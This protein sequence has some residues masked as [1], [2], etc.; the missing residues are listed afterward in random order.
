M[1]GGQNAPT[2]AAVEAQG[3]RH[4]APAPVRASA[5]KQKVRAAARRYKAGLRKETAMAAEAERL[6]ASK[7]WL[8]KG[9]V[10]QPT[11]V[12]RGGLPTLGKRR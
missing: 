2:R 12:V 3:A 9:Y 1:A 5:R 10:P 11:T 7:S 4:S 8:P 6:E